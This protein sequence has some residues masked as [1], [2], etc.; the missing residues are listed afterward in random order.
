MLANEFTS[1]ADGAPPPG[2]PAATAKQ[3]HVYTVTDGQVFDPAS[4]RMIPLKKLALWRTDPFS[5]DFKL[6][7]IDLAIL[8]EKY[9]LAL[10]L[11]EKELAQ[12]PN[13]VPALINKGVALAELGSPG[14][15]LQVNRQILVRDPHNAAALHNAALNLAELGDYA[16][17]LRLM[18]RSIAI[19]TSYAPAYV[20]RGHI[21]M[22]LG[23]F[24]E[25]LN[26]YERALNTTSFGALNSVR[27]DYVL[28]RLGAVPSGGYG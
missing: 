16:E 25:G 5:P 9:D 21:L 20:H 27:Q 23:R 14:A 12:D 19:D 13:D 7:E 22:A 24:E 28:E 3:N 18:D 10:N 4:G 6:T 15:A 2:Q 8:D 26:A 11:A 17:A 1:N